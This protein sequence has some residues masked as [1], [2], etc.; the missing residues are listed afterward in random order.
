LILLAC[1]PQFSTPAVQISDEDYQNVLDRVATSKGFA[2]V[3]DN[4]LFFLQVVSP[5]RN[6]PVA[7]RTLNFLLRGRCCW[8]KYLPAIPKGLPPA[9]AK[10]MSQRRKMAIRTFEAMSVLDISKGMMRDEDI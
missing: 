5:C 7:G 3:R 9:D 8:Q 1:S 4:I 2:V 6:V 10:K